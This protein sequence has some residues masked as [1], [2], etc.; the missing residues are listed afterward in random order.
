MLKGIINSKSKTF[1]T[2][3]FF[4]LIGIA[5]ASLINQKID[6]VFIYLAAFI[7]VAFVFIYKDDKKIQFTIYC[8]LITLVGFTRYNFALPKDFKL[9]ENKE[10]ITGYISSEPDVR[11]YGVRYI[12]LVNSEQKT[13]NRIKRKLYFKS[14]LYPRYKYGDELELTC[15]L[16]NPEPIDN[17]RYDMYLANFGV[18]AICRNPKIEKIG[19][20][21]GNV[22]LS[23]V[24]AVKNTVASKVNQL[25]HEPYA[26]FMAGLLYGYRGGLGSLNELFNITGVTHIIAISGYNITIVASILMAIFVNLRINRKK[27]FWL[28]VLGIILFVIFAGASA[29]VVRA[30]IMGVL[31][32]LARQMGRRNKV[33]NAMAL[34]AVVMTLHNPFVL[35]WDAGFQLS[36]LATIGLVYFNPILEKRFR[37]I[38]EFM[39]LKESFISTISAITITLPLILYQFGRLSF[40]A[41]IV[42]VLI[43]W[44]IPWIMLVGFLAVFAAF[45]FEP[46]GL[47]LAW[48]GWLGMKYVT[49]VVEFFARLPFAAYDFSISVWVM[50]FL[51]IWSFVFYKKIY[52]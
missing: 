25:W 7:L 23:G 17:F 8:L 19:T 14:Q 1:L 31:V 27:A 21:E 20:G 40:V 24:F 41:P 28:I 47:V 39:G 46:F 45:V 49:L 11:Q 51:Y 2:F 30:G 42:N 35:V 22:V 29:S 44:L 32:L 52:L 12:V 50:I 10:T 5:I 37:S 9:P 18:F 15:K 36:F 4:F 48:V 6:F 13:V 16:E 33:A 3:C 34:T 38:P 43:L 26:G